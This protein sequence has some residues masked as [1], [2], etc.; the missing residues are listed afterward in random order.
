MYKAAVAYIVLF[1][2]AIAE[3]NNNEYGCLGPQECKW[4]CP[5]KE[6]GQNLRRQISSFGKQG[7]V[8]EKNIFLV[9]AGKEKFERPTV[10]WTWVLAF[11][12]NTTSAQAGSEVSFTFLLDFHKAFFDQVISLA[13]TTTLF[14]LIIFPEISTILRQT[15]AL[16]PA[17][18]HA[19]KMVSCW[20]D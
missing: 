11:A 8:L 4:V 17:W 18:R 7:E 6:S 1:R 13:A 20:Q 5:R 12:T 14:H 2:G 3:I 9:L 16:L 15:W 19:G 10:R